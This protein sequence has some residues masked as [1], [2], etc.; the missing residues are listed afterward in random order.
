MET[1]NVVLYVRIFDVFVGG[2]ELYLA[3]THALSTPLIDEWTDGRM[4][5][6]AISG[7]GKIVHRCVMAAWLEY[8]REFVNIHLGSYS[9]I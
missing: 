1:V 4:D 6:I 8:I 7:K 5:S 9:K 2:F 3:W